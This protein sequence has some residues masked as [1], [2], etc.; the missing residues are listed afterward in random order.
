MHFLYT[1]TD[2]NET[3]Q[4]D[5]GFLLAVL[6]QPYTCWQS[7][8]GDSAVQVKED[9]RLIF[10]KTDRGVFIMQHPDYLAPRIQADENILTH[11]IG[12]EPML[13]PMAC[14]CTEEVAFSI[15]QYYISS[16]GLLLP[17][18][19]WVEFPALTMY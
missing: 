4:E 12:G 18:Y 2:G 17:A 1:D 8:A 5:T 7:G 10:F 15:L 11:A 19:E 9:E 14:V 6:A 13:V 3:A 16:G